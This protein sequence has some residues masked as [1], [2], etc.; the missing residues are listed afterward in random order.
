MRT[1]ISTYRLQVGSIGVAEASAYAPYLAALGISDAYVSP[2]LRAGS[3]HGYDVLD[4]SVADDRVG[5]DAG[6]ADLARRLADEGLGVLLDIVPNHMAV[7]PE[8]PWWWDVLEHGRASRFA[9][10]FDIT[11]EPP[12]AP[13]LS[14][15]LVLPVLGSSFG[16][17]VRSSITI[18]VDDTRPALVA[19]YHDRT[20]PIDPATYGAV[21]AWAEESALRGL[22]SAASRVPWR[23][24]AQADERSQAT[25]GVRTA[26][27]RIVDDPAAR[28][29][30]VSALGLLNGSGE[31]AVAA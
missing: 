2:V 9:T 23:D 20:F 12:E 3:D 5:G 11:W 6:F 10:F 7:S 17:E 25:A 4:P 26:L 15:R 21:E 28:S 1:P 18:G 30:L 8:N 13:E 16:Q 14:G 27:H 22:W 24:G 31:S 29:A 19:R